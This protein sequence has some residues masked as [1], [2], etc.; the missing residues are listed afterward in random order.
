MRD[1]SSIVRAP[2]LPTFSAYSEDEGPRSQPR[3]LRV[4]IAGIL[5]AAAPGLGQLYNGQFSK[6]LCVAAILP[7]LFLAIGY[8][9]VL[10]SFAGLIVTIL[11][12]FIWRIVAIVD[13]LRVAWRQSSISDEMPATLKIA[14]SVLIALLAFIP[15]PERF[16][17]YFV[18]LRAYSLTSDSMCPA[19]CPEDNFVADASFFVEH[20]PSRGDMAV[21]LRR[22][23]DIISVKRIVGLPGDVVSESDSGEI[24]VN[25][26][27]LHL[28]LL[29]QSCG[30]LSPST[31]DLSRDKPFEHVAVP[32]DSFFVV[33]DKRAHSY[34]SREPT[35][36]FVRRSELLGKPKYIYWS[37]DRSRVGC[38]PR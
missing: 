24:R 31:V 12:A 18:Y 1:L 10:L 15:V 27:P 2:D 32:K 25:D 19:L 13:A 3:W 17:Q 36:G 14:A 6:A 8:S 28:P 16:L 23:S 26:Q 7:G 20:S 29:V 35:F 9:R 4:P 22:G 21:F 37:I 11:A 5:T 33:G 30:K 34:D 38:Q